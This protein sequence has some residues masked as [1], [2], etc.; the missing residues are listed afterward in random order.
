MKK[1][2]E[3][4]SEMGLDKA[5]E[6]VAQN[7]TQYRTEVHSLIADQ[8]VEGI[9]FGRCFFPDK[10]IKEMLYDLCDNTALDF[11]IRFQAI[12]EVLTEQETPDDLKETWLKLILKNHEE[13]RGIC[14]KTYSLDTDINI[15]NY[16]KKLINNKIPETPSNKKWVYFIELVILF[17]T[18]DNIPNIINTQIEGSSDSFL[19]EAGNEC[20]AFLKAE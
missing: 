9:C 20:L 18:M 4:L 7:A 11:E 17:R 8:I 2:N 13:F 14:K 12:Y 3:L 15:D 16:F 1:I 6:F 19:K 5:R 10:D